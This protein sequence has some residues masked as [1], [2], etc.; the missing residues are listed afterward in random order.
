MD[1]NIE[2]VRSSLV[3]TYADLRIRMIASGDDGGG[4]P[5]N[6]APYSNTIVKQ[7]LKQTSLGPS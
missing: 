5:A 7:P 2:A 4:Q 1:T 3:K 6:D